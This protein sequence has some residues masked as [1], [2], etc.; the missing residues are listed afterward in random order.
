L[1]ITFVIISHDVKSA[2]TVAHRIA[3]IYQGSIIGVLTP[4]EIRESAN[5][6]LQQFIAG[7]AQ[8]PITWVE[9]EG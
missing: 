8:G 2:F 7:T 6:I 9:V 3:M 5:P 4:D 1:G